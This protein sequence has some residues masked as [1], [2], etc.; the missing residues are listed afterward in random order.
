MSD[1]MSLDNIVTENGEPG[2][3]NSSEMMWIPGG[4]F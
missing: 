4:T 1:A 3:S 2:H